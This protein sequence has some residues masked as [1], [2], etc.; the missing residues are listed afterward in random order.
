MEAVMAGDGGRQRYEEAGGG[1][2]GPVV[3]GD[4]GV[5]AERGGVLGPGAAV[6]ARMTPTEPRTWT[7]SGTD[8]T[9][10]V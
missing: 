6:P 3:G 5:G 2:G 9:R 4:V 1:A 8:G 7:L 10:D